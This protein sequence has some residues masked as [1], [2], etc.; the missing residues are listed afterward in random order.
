[1]NNIEHPNHYQLNVNLEVLDIIKLVLDN[2]NVSHYEGFI[3][4][5]AIKY[6]YRAS[7]KNGVEDIKKAQYYLELLTQSKYQITLTRFESHIIRQSVKK[8]EQEEIKTALHSL[9][10]LMI[11]DTQLHIENYIKSII[12]NKE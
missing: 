8:I 4:G 12:E 6:L 5:N 2:A 1:M 10:N 9:L 7:K 11:T 3:I